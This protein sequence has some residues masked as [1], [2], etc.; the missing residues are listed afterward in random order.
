M[1][2]VTAL[3][4]I[5]DE[6]LVKMPMMHAQ[7]ADVVVG[8]LSV[9]KPNALFRYTTDRLTEEDAKQNNCALKD[10]KLRYKQQNLGFFEG[11]CASLV[12]KIFR[13]APFASDFPKADDVSLLV[14][15]FT[16]LLNCVK[17]FRKN[18]PES[19]AFHILME[20]LYLQQTCEAL[21][22]V[23]NYLSATVSFCSSV[24]MDGGLYHSLN[25]SRLR[26][27]ARGCL[28]QLFTMDWFLPDAE[29]E[30]V[31]VLDVLKYSLQ[32]GDVARLADFKGVV[33]ACF[34]QY[35]DSYG[36]PQAAVVP[37]KF[38]Y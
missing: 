2:D 12:L 7:L 28:T 21:L 33:K 29:D 5:V 11:A 34:A 23:P 17:S 36:V 24:L 38:D 30:V 13:S 37:I 8:V 3:Y 1:V 32:D 10:L 26:N 25:G 31:H 19:P 15:V 9:L 20:T 4:T 35:V 16:P 18:T 6:L 14:A 22:R 27:A